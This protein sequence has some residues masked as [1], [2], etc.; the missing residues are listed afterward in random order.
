MN[1][2]TELKAYKAALEAEAEAT[3]LANDLKRTVKTTAARLNIEFA[4]SGEKMT[5]D[6]RNSR[7]E[8][9]ADYQSISD[10]YADAE[11]DMLRAK[12]ALEAARAEYVLHN[13]VYAGQSRLALS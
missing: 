2:Q 3:I 5:A 7:I 12:A 9:N 6:V 8:V 13:V 10:A 1:G 11:A 4:E